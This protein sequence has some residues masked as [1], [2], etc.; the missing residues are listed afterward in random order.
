LYR[1][2]LASA[3]ANRSLVRKEEDGKREA[4]GETCRWLADHGEPPAQ[5]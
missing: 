5:G 2:A 3:I 1:K 4:L